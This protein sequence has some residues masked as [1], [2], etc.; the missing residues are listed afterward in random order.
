MRLQEVEAVF[1][2]LQHEHCRALSRLETEHFF[3]KADVLIDEHFFAGFVKQG[4]LVI[5]GNEV[6]LSLVATLSLM[7]L[8]EAIDHGFVADTT[9]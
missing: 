6:R 2:H 4:N 5:V 8:V 3:N 9:H 1:L 7:L